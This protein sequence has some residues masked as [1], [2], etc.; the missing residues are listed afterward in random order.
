MVTR[1]GMD[2][3]EELPTVGLLDTSVFIASESGRPLNK[4]ALPGVASAST[5]CGSPPLP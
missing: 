4:A 3:D 1:L 5:I 2:D